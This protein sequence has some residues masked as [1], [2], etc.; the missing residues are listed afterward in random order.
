MV[1]G[2]FFV[3]LWLNARCHLGHNIVPGI[4]PEG[5]LL[6]HGANSETIPQG[7]E[8]AALDFEHAHIYCRQRTFLSS[9]QRGC[10]QLTLTTTRPLKV[11]YF[12]GFS[13]ANIPGPLDTQDLLAFGESLSNPERMLDETE[14]GKALCRWGRN[15]SV[16][17]F[18]R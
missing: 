18:V 4:I 7:I 6:Y 11:V 16:D 5:T 3:G 9:S 13:A 8:W 15:V 12:D 14:R 2:L 1:C 10:W 17:G